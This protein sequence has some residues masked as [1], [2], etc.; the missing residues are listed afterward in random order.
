MFWVPELSNTYLMHLPT[1]SFNST[2][3]SRRGFTLVELL[4]VIAIIAILVGL[5]LP[6]VQQ[7]REAARR[8]HCSNNIKQIALALHNYESAHKRF[9]PAGIGYSWCSSAAGG[10]GSKLMM[11]ANG[12]LQ[13]L[14]Y[15]EQ[16]QVYNTFNHGESYAMTGGTATRNSNGIFT[17]NPAANGNAK[18]AGRV[19]AVFDCPSD[20]T[21]PLDRPLFGPHYGPHPDSTR[22]SDF[23][24]ATNYDFI[25]AYQDFSYCNYWRNS[26]TNKRMFGENSDTRMASVSDGLSNTLAIG[27]T[28]KCHVNGRAFAWAYRTWVMSGIDPAHPTQCCI[29]LW[30]LPSVD[31]SW[32]SP[33]YSPVFGNVRTWWAAAASLHP[34]GCHFGFGDGSVHFLSQTTNYVTMLHLARISDGE[35]VEFPQ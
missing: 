29:N 11:N 15:M 31:P 2:K 22:S 33:P 27:E 14:P 4:V 25:T 35:P 24:T 18:A 5:L 13:L 32:E 6:A 8:I 21:G 34:G 16:L 19:M 7:A 3:S 1:F 30:H 17:G 12:L 10:N 23:G 20:K 9:P 26:G 28:T